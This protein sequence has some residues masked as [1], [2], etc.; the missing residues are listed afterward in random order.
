MARSR[1]DSF[2]VTVRVVHSLPDVCEIT[3]PMLS[4]QNLTDP[5]ESIH[6]AMDFGLPLDGDPEVLHQAQRCLVAYIGWL[7]DEA[8]ARYPSWARDELRRA[9]KRLVEVQ[10]AAQYVIPRLH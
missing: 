1:S 4:Q 6:A 7:L 9:I 2:V 3:G 8:A 10:T 5:E